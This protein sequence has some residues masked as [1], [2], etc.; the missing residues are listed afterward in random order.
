MG[1]R[2]KKYLLWFLIAFVI[3]AIFK[4]PEQAAN[5]VRSAVD[6]ILTVFSG[7]GRFFDALLSQR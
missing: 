5:L 1:P 2:I 4:S 7:V 3:Y 6:G